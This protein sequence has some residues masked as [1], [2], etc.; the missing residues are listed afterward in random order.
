MSLLL[1]DGVLRGRSFLWR[2]ALLETPLSFFSPALLRSFR[3][4][5]FFFRLALLLLFR[6]GFELLLSPES[7]ALD[8]LTPPCESWPI[9][10]VPPF[11]EET[12]PP[13]WGVPPSC[14]EEEDLL[15]FFLPRS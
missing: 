13:D 7:E 6:L 5:C 3:L 12:P 11:L 9:A 2:F 14:L 1:G 15:F 10:L 4:F 8:R